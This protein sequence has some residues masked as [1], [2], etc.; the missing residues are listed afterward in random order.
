M[1]MANTLKPTGLKVLAVTHQHPCSFMYSNPTKTFWIFS[2]LFWNL[3]TGKKTRY[4]NDPDWSALVTLVPDC[5]CRAK[6]SKCISITK[7]CLR[8][9]WET[10]S[11]QKTQF[12]D[13]LRRSVSSLLGPQRLSLWKHHD[14]IREQHTQHHKLRGLQASHRDWPHLNHVSSRLYRKLLLARKWRECRDIILL[15][16]EPVSLS[17][18]TYV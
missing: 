6:N 9:K 15:F 13:L 14:Y 5:C 4:F 1:A 12:L 8:V 11:A 2:G 17:K 10:C 16:F 18:W 7:A 3:K